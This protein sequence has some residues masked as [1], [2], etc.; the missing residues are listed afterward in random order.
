MHVG[1]DKAGKDRVS[2]DRHRIAGSPVIRS[3]SRDPAVRDNYVGRL[4]PFGEDIDDVTAMQQQI[5]G[6]LPKRD[7]HTPLKRGNVEIHRGFTRTHLAEG[8]RAVPLG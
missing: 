4:N 2:G 5:P 1:V 6:F 8:G 3:D 7:A